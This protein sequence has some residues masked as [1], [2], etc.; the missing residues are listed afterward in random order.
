[1][2]DNPFFLSSS[3]GLTE[4]SAAIAASGKL[5]GDLRRR[6]DFSERFSELALDQTPFFRLVSMLS[7]KPTDDP[8][9]KFTE[10]R[11]SFLKRYAYVVGWAHGSAGAAGTAVW[12][13]A[14]VRAIDNDSG[15][16]VVGD[17]VKLLMAGDYLSAGNIQNVSGQSNG[18]IMVGAA[19]TAPEF[20]LKNQIIK[21][22]MSSTANGGAMT[23]YML[24]RITLDP[25]AVTGHDFSANS[26][27]GPSGGTYVRIEGT[28][29]RY[30]GTHKELASF[31]GN[32]A[33]YEV[34]DESIAESLEA[35][36]S[37]VVGNSFEEGS[38]LIDKQWKDNPYSTGYGATQIFRTEF[39]MTNTARA[40]ALKY[41]PNEWARIWKDKLIEHK[42]DIEHAGLFS[43]QYKSGSVQHTQGAIDYVL[44]YGNLFSLDT[45]TK[46]IDDFLDDMSK[47]QDPRYNQDKA[48]VFLCSTA[49]YTWLH[50]LGGFFRNNLAIG[51]QATQN[52]AG[53]ENV[54][55]HGLFG[56]DLAVTGRKKVMGLD[57]TTFS[58]VYGDMNVSRCIA[59]DGSQVKVLALNL[60]NVA[61]R[62]LVGNGINR[63]TSIYVGVQG[64]ENTGRDERVDMILTEAGFEYKM[65][66]SHAIWK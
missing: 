52:V 56:A 53:N 43:T 21:V 4:S 46:T 45:G 12:N 18:K 48:T 31:S 20:F 5:T 35:K 55:G 50:K 29:L 22:P 30:D 42:W 10:K 41:E 63:D 32:K 23:D 51:N 33:D 26:I 1:M 6:Y 13:D 14:Q 24:V 28:V 59:L 17:T 7:K 62:P 37:Y 38:G 11:Q 34:Y 16:L 58:T 40:T 2:A 54:G 44:N 25:A 66:E 57:V 15:V 36:R 64:L 39:G 3:T 8:E 19:G 9:F 61:Y 65:P 60:N 27:G 49:V 47:Y